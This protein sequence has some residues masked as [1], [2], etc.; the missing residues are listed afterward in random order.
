MY[1]RFAPPS[2]EDEQIDSPL[3]L[4]DGYFDK[5]L[6][7]WVLSRFEDVAAAFKCHALSQ[8]GPRS[9]FKECPADDAVR[10]KMRA[11]T[12]EALSSATLEGWRNEI[13]RSAA[14]LLDHFADIRPVDLVAEYAEPLCLEIARLVTGITD[15]GQANLTQLAR[16]I[17]EAAA[18]P[19]DPDLARQAKEA[20]AVL[21]QYFR[22]GPVSLKESGFVALSQTLCH[23]LARCWYA[24]LRHPSEWERLH[25]EPGLIGAAVEELLRYAGLTRILFRMANED[26]EI[27][28]KPIRKGERLILRLAAANRDPAAFE[29]AD[30]PNIA[31]ERRHHLAL[32]LGRHGCVG[33]PLIRLAVNMATRLLVERYKCADLEREITWRGGS[34]FR[35]PNSLRVALHAT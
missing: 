2:W 20:N 7:A 9:T 23:M 33:A 10:L 15:S 31:A 3:Q 16:K 28:G 11:E 1:T 27:N 5:A 35:Y 12:A 8:A 29:N 6:N 32:G 14:A 13:G 19:F 22:S 30:L 26:V 17:S 18:E 25:R 4:E 21:C 24:L 34:G